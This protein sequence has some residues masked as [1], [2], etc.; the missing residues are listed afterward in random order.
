MATDKTNKPKITSSGIG[1]RKESI[2]SVRLL[3]GNG[4]VTVNTQ[5]IDQYFPSAFESQKYSQP[6]KI[7][8]ADK[9]DATIKV[10]GGGKAGQLDAVVLGLARALSEIKDQ[11]KIS[12]RAAGLLTRDSRIRQR[13][14][15]G[16]GGKSRR[17]KQSPKR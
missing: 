1:R 7:T 8:G 16:T 17:R 9:Y 3:A 6:F 13:R 10:F 14:M 15:V 4:Q 5:P 12:L 2:A 11:Y